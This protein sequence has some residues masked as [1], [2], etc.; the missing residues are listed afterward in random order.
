MNLYDTKQFSVTYGIC[1]HPAGCRLSCPGVDCVLCCVVLCCTLF[2]YIINILSGLS[3]FWVGAGVRG[4]KK[5]LGQHCWS[6]LFDRN[7][8]CAPKT[9]HLQGKAIP[10]QAFWAPGG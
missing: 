5:C 1:Q 6:L 9:E 4:D 7:D 10:G 8:Y 2:V 3:F